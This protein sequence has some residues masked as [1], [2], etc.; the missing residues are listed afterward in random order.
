MIKIDTD[1]PVPTK[2]M[3]TRKYPYPDLE[4]GQSFL[5]PHAER[6]TLASGACQV[7]KKLGRKFKTQKTRE[8][9]RVWRVA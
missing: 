5:A 7:G 2:P 8:G 1:I 4:V 6:A 9:V 3:R